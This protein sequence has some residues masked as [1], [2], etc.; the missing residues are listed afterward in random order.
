MRK[1]LHHVKF[2]NMCNILPCTSAVTP[3]ALIWFINDPFS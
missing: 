2:R 3:V 1:L